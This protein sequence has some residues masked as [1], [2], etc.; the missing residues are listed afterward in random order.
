[1]HWLAWLPPPLEPG[2]APHPGQPWQSRGWWAL[3]FTPR[4]AW[5]EEALVLEVSATERLWGGR[6][7]LRALLQ[8]Q[9]P[10]AQPHAEVGGPEASCWAEAPTAWQALALL[11]LQQEGC[12]V[13]RRLPHDLPI[14]TLS[15]LRPHAQA[16]AQLGCRTWGELRGL[17]RAGLARRF[18]AAS[19]AALDQAWEPGA[20]A[21]WRW[22]RVPESFDL[23]VELPAPAESAEALLWTGQRLLGALQD[24]LRARQQGVLA[25]ELRWHHNLR[26]SAGRD[27]PAWQRLELR[28]A[29][30]A[31]EMAHLRRL[32]AERLARYSLAAPADRLGLC[33]LQTAPLPQASRSLLLPGPGE[34]APGEAWHQLLER[35]AERLGPENLRQPVPCDDHRPERMQR[36]LPAGEAAPAAPAPGGRGALLPG[37][38]VR[39]PRPLALQDGQPCLQ[40]EPLRLL[41][42]PERLETGWWEE[43]AEDVK[44]GQ[45]GLA[46]RDYFIARGRA[47]WVWVFRD[48]A[49]GAW[50]LQGVY[51]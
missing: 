45:G 15:A 38:L 51:A 22:L 47:G 3:R 13:P 46:R 11:R 36:W 42:G 35:L 25:L 1:M 49:D 9:A 40:G 39:P 8:S 14:D 27:L 33:S 24:W 2:V 28:T 23:E 50:Y 26:R 44:G 20:Q 4:V 34:Q 41:A 10:H 43:Q 29:E 31:Q 5:L 21:A 37:W 18:G 16:L 19:L 30:P 7:R 17:P 12:P 6:Q 32:L 48:Q